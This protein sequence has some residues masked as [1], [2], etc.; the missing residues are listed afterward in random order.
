MLYYSL[1][2]RWVLGA[3]NRIHVEKAHLF[4]QE[5]DCILQRAAQPSKLLCNSLH[6]RHVY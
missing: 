4:E 2:L 5:T 6:H 1:V 3:E